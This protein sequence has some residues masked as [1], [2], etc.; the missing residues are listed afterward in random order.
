MNETIIAVPYAGLC[1]RLRMIA[2]SVQIAS[3]LEAKIDVLWQNSPDCGARFDDVFNPVSLPFVK[4]Y[5]CNGLPLIF[6]R[7]RLRNIYIYKCI[8]RLLGY[9]SI[10]GYKVDSNKNI[11]EYMKSNK[12]YF[13]SCHSMCNH[14]PFDKLFVPNSELLNIIHDISKNFN[15]TYGLHIRRTDNKQ[16]IKHSGIDKFENVI[17][18]LIREEDANFYLATDSNDVKIYLR[19]KFPNKI[20]TYDALLQRNSSLGIKDAVVDLWVLS[21]TIKIYG[22]FY[23]SYSEV[24]AELSSIPLEIL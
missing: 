14:Y 2:S 17:Q 13:S 10:E 4:V 1:N 20:I 6:K 21:R 18:K 7:S 5:D 12:L 23:S 8:R 19:K 11:F 9:Q 22:S 15:K 3:V 16:S 24:A